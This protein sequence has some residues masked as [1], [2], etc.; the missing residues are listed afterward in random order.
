MLSASLE[1]GGP[2]EH[3]KLGH[4]RSTKLMI[5]PTLDQLHLTPPL[6]PLTTEQNLKFSGMGYYAL[7]VLPNDQCQNTEENTQR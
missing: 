7:N 1:K 4:C 3:D 2:S 6:P 5:S